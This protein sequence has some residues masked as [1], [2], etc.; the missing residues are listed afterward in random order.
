MPMR[1]VISGE[2]G[3]DPAPC[4]GEACAEHCHRRGGAVH[5]AQQVWQQACH[6]KADKHERDRQLLGGVSGA[7]RG[8]G[9]AGA[10]DADHDCGHREVLVAS[11]MLAEHSLSD[12]QQHKQAKCECRLHYNQWRQHQRENL[13][14]PAE[15]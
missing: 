11:S 10:N 6:P 15:S 4:K 3:G 2:L 1:E 5:D 7:A 8:G 9:Q 14:R 13:Q 12:E